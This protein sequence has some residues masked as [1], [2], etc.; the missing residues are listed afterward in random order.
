MSQPWRFTRWQTSSLGFNCTM[1]FLVLFCPSSFLSVCL[2]TVC[3]LSCSYL[4][5]HFLSS[6]HMAG[7]TCMVISNLLLLQ[8][9]IDSSNSV[10]KLD[11]SECKNINKASLFI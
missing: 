1:S 2:V 8:S 11:V 6:H 3:R 9:N 5:F 10:G 7:K 4:M